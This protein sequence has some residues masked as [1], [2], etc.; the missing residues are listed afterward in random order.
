MNAKDKQFIEK[1][2]KESVA[3]AQESINLVNNI[4][5]EAPSQGHKFAILVL[6]IE[7]MEKHLASMAEQSLEYDSKANIDGM[8]AM[9]RYI[10]KDSLIE[11]RI[12]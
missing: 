6:T 10:A 5:N 3:L 8:I 1:S 9:L 12:K 7:A 2:I 4:V 11:V